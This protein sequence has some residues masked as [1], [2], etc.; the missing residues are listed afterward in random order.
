MPRR[1]Y[2]AT[3]PTILHQAIRVSTIALRRIRLAYS[4]SIITSRQLRRDKYVS[5]VPSYV[6]RFRFC[7]YASAVVSRHYASTPASSPSY[8]RNVLSLNK[9]LDNYVSTITSRQLRLDN[10][11]S[12]ITSRHRR[13]RRIEVN[14][15]PVCSA[16]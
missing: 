5:P 10:Y 11:V 9:H 1:L 7:Q 4:A 3:A 8:L 14:V 16:L 2:L 12:T 13:R 6:S 15:P